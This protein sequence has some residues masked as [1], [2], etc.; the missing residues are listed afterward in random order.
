[1]AVKRTTKRTKATTN[2]TRR[3]VGLFGII[4][5]QFKGEPRK[6]IKHLKKVK[7]GECPKALYRDDIGYID[8]VWGEV[9]DKIKHTG[10]GLAHIIDKHG[11]E[12]KQLGFEVEDFIPIV[13]Q[14]GNLKESESKEEFLLESNM[15]RVVI[16]KKAF[17]TTKKWLLTAFDLRKKRLP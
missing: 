5:R 7:Q 8:V 1:M 13:I 11:K 10:Y 4:Y 12:I 6:A 15:F 3:K 14:Y 16:E 2:Y 17:G 9:T